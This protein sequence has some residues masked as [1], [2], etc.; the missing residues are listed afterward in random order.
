MWWVFLVLLLPSFQG[1]EVEKQ[2]KG[3]NIHSSYKPCMC[4]ICPTLCRS[5][6]YHVQESSTSITSFEC[7]V[8]LCHSFGFKE[9]LWRSTKFSESSWACWSPGLVTHFLMYT[10][11]YLEKFPLTKHALSSY[12][13]SKA[14]KLIF[15]CVE[16]KKQKLDCHKSK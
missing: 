7:I 2:K 9:L 3:K 15:S 5:L 11:F 10:V 14:D 12:T 16:L 4:T 6:H 8:L 13:S 1:K